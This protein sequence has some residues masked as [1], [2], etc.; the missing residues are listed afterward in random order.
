MTYFDDDDIDFD[1]IDFDLN[2]EE[3][4][5]DFD[6][7]E[8][9]V[10]EQPVGNPIYL[11]SN[12]TEVG[13]FAINAMALRTFYENALHLDRKD[14]ETS[15][16]L[17]VVNNYCFIYSLNIGIGLTATFG[18]DYPSPTPLVVTLP[19][20]KILKLLNT[21]EMVQFD[22]TEDEV[23]ISKSNMRVSI[24]RPHMLFVRESDR[25]IEEM[26]AYFVSGVHDEFSNTELLSMLS[27]MNTYSRLNQ[28]D[29]RIIILDGSV[30]YV[31]SVGY[32]VHQSFKS[33]KKYLINTTFA[34]L[35]IKL[36]KSGQLENY[37]I[38]IIIKEDVY[39]IMA[40][41]YILTFPI[42]D[43]EGKFTILGKIQPTTVYALDKKE[44][45]TALSQ[46]DMYTE[47]NCA[48][49]L[50][51]TVSIQN[52][53]VQGTA[54]VQLGFEKL[55]DSRQDKT[56]ATYVFDYNKLNKVLTPLKSDRIHVM[57]CNTRE[58]LYITDDKMTFYIILSVK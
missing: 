5:I 37:P 39:V 36:C 15:I 13:S 52:K 23:V 20:N 33:N 28:A 48:I 47:K 11:G 50:G 1:D 40:N 49:T 17:T 16:T 7:E 10:I 22:M 8:Q 58:H 25:A 35:L 44:L 19:I 9:T 2:N 57:E 4:D 41:N 54:Y 18:C 53:T 56:N 29:K 26:Y 38:K 43:G 24:Q 3:D 12:Y 51:D 21:D 34:N 27:I 32:Y 31:K 14:S 45:K 46:I 30:A 6:Y 55:E 42:L